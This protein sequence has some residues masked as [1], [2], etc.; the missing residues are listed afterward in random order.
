MVSDHKNVS[1]LPNG[2]LT[3]AALAALRDMD[4]AFCAAINLAVKSGVPQGLIVAMLHGH[5]HV[6][7]EIMVTG[8]S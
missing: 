3:P 2:T 7:T 8:D 4:K 6:Q 1:L 5:A